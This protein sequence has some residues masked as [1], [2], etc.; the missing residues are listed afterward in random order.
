MMFA[1]FGRFNVRD[2]RRLDR[3]GMYLSG[4]FEGRVKRVTSRRRQKRA[5][6]ECFD[7][8]IA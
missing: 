8:L 2:L 4:M 3:G 5:I 6:L 1:R 7:Q